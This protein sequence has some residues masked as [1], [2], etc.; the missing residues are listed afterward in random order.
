[1]QYNFFFQ[2]IHITDNKGTQFGIK[3][4]L[5]TSIVI[6]LKKCQFHCAMPIPISLLFIMTMYMI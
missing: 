2:M 1:M 6:L 5:F 3:K 4:F